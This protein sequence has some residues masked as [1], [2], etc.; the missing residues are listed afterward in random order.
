MSHHQS[1]F[2]IIGSGIAGLSF[3]LKAAEHGLVSI[4]NKG[5]TT[6]SNSAWAQGGISSVL[7]QPLCSEDDSNQLHLEDTIQAGSGLC[8]PDN[9]KILIDQGDRCINDLIS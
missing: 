6:E 8:D 1:D 9:A 7:S 3:A 5:S 2:L 4:I